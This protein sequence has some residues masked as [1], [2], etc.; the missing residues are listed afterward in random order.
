MYRKSAVFLIVLFLSLEPGTTAH[1]QVAPSQISRKLMAKS[2]DAV[3]GDYRNL[4]WKT[5][6]TD[7]LD[8][9]A[10]DL[11]QKQSLPDTLYIGTVETGQGERWIVPDIAPS[12]SETFSFV[13]YL[14]PQKEI[15]DVDILEYRES[16]GYE[17]DY[18]FF[19]AQFHGKSKPEEIR[20]RRSIQNISGATISARSITWAVHDL[21][22]IINHINLEP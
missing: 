15:V 3:L 20:F 12:R 8:E 21:M 6:R 14:D 19:R 4:E 18:P 16:Y 10:L 13:L 7:V 9:E 17:I 1:A 5:V 11:R 22:S 2:M